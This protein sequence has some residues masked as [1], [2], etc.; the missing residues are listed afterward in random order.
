MGAP[1]SYEE[2]QLQTYGNVAPKTAQSLYGPTGAPPQSAP[3]PPP[4]E[5]VPTNFGPAPPPANPQPTPVYRE[6]APVQPAPVGPTPQEQY[7]VQQMP[8]QLDT[9]RRRD[10]SLGVINQ[11]GQP[12]TANPGGPLFNQ[13][14]FD[15]SGRGSQAYE[16]AL[17]SEA[18]R[19][20]EKPSGVESSA[21]GVKE[22]IGSIL[23]DQLDT[24]GGWLGG[25][26]DAV[27]GRVGV[28][29]G[30]ARQ[31]AQKTAV[32]PPAPNGQRGSGMP[33]LGDVAGAVARGAVEGF[34]AEPDV[35]RKPAAT[36]FGIVQGASRPQMQV[37]EVLGQRAIDRVLHGDENY[38]YD[39][40]AMTGLY[41]DFVNA[42]FSPID[43]IEWTRRPDS[44]PIIE[45][46][47]SDGYNGYTGGQAIYQFWRDQQGLGGV[48]S[49][50]AHDPTAPLEVGLALATGGGSAA[51]EFVGRRAGKEAVGMATANV[52]RNVGRTATA[53]A[54]DPFDAGPLIAKGTRAVL[55]GVA[56]TVGGTADRIY[57]NVILTERGR[58]EVQQ[59]EAEQIGQAAARGIVDRR[60]A[61][62][63]PWLFER[64]VSNN[65][66]IDPA[67]NRPLVRD[68]RTG[69]IRPVEE[70]DWARAMQIMGTIPH[71]R[72]TQRIA[73]T[74]SPL[75][76]MERDWLDL[77][78]DRAR[79]RAA[80]LG[81]PVE[82]LYPRHGPQYE[83]SVGMHAMRMQRYG[84]EVVDGL[85][86]KAKAAFDAD[87]RALNTLR[88]SGAK[89]TDP[90]LKAAQNR[91]VNAAYRAHAIE[92]ARAIAGIPDARAARHG[93]WASQF[94][95]VAKTLPK[96]GPSVQQQAMQAS[97]AASG[98]RLPWDQDL[99]LPD[100]DM[101]YL[102]Q[103]MSGSGAAYGEEITNIVADLR[104]LHDLADDAAARAATGEALSKWD[105][106]ELTALMTR[107]RHL[108]PEGFDPKNVASQQQALDAIRAW[109]EDVTAQLAG[110]EFRQRVAMDRGYLDA[111]GNATPA[112]WVG[113]PDG[114]LPAPVNWF[115]QN[116]LDRT[117]RGTGKWLLH[118][119]ARAPAFAALQ[120]TGNL[121]GK[122][123]SQSSP[124]AIVSYLNPK[125]WVRGFKQLMGDQSVL[126]NYDRY[127]QAKGLGSSERVR[128]T[129]D[130][131]RYGSVEG[132]AKGYFTAAKNA[133][134][135]FDLANAQTAFMGEVL[136][137]EK[138]LQRWLRLPAGNR[139]DGFT[140]RNVRTPIE[141]ARN[142]GI[143]ATRVPDAAI[144]R[145]L[146]AA[147]AG[148]WNGVLSAQD[149][150]NALYRAANVQQGADPLIDQWVDRVGR[151]YVNLS[152][153][154]EAQGLAEKDRVAFSWNETK[155]D[156][157]LSRMFLFHYWNSRASY[158]YTRNLLGSPAMLNA[159]VS[160]FRSLEQEAEREGYPDWLR[161]WARFMQ[162]P[163][164]IGVFT[165]PTATF[166]TMLTF[167]SEAWQGDDEFY[168]RVTPLGKA[169]EKSPAMVHPVWDNLFA[170]SGMYGADARPS[171]ILP[172]A[173]LN[174]EIYDLA[175][176][177]GVKS[178]LADTPLDARWRNIAGGENSRAIAEFVQD[179]I[180]D[181]DEPMR[182]RDPNATRDKQIYFLMLQAAMDSEGLTLDQAVERVNQEGGQ[183][184]PDSPLYQSAVNTL[185]EAPFLG[186]TFGIEPESVPGYLVGAIASRLGPYPARFDVTLQTQ[187]GN[188]IGRYL[189]MQD[190]GSTYQQI[191]DATMNEP[192]RVGGYRLQVPGTFSSIDAGGTVY[193]PDEV[194][195]MTPE[196]RYALAEQ[197]IAARFPLPEGQQED[198]SYPEDAQAAME[199]ARATSPE[200]LARQQAA[201]DY[202]APSDPEAAL[203]YEVY[204]AIG[205][206]EL[207]GTVTL[208]FGEGI[209]PE[210]YDNE[211]LQKLT[212]GEKWDI[213]EAWAQLTGA[214]PLI[215]EF[216]AQQRE[217]AATY[218]EIA[219]EMELGK[220]AGEYAGGEI[221]F[222]ED[223]MALN[224]NYAEYATTLDP[225]R[226]PPGSKDWAGKM[227]D[228]DGYLVLTG[229]RPRNTSPLAWDK[230]GAGMLPEGGTTSGLPAAN[231]EREAAFAEGSEFE[232]NVRAD[233][234]RLNAMFVAADAYDA[235]MGYAP[236][237]SRGI[238]LQQLVTGDTKT[239]R[240]DKALYDA[241][242]AQYGTEYGLIPT[243][244]SAARE[245]ALWAMRQPE[246]Q[247]DLDTFFALSTLEW[248]A[249]QRAEG[250]VV[251]DP[252]TGQ[253]TVIPP[254]EIERDPA[255]D[256]SFLSGVSLQRSADNSGAFLST[257]PIPSRP[258]QS[259][260]TPV[261]E[262]VTVGALGGTLYS[263]PD[264][265]SQPLVMLPADTP[266][267]VVA[268]A[269]RFVQ[270]RDPLGMT[271]YVAKPMLTKGANATTA[272]AAVT[273]P[274]Q[275]PVSSPTTTTIPPKVRGTPYVI[276]MTSYVSPNREPRS[277]PPE[278]IVYHYTVGDLDSFAADF[279]GQTGRQASANYVVDRD[280]TIY[281]FVDP[282]D[283]AWTH[284]DTNQ[285]RTDLPWLAEKIAQGY[286]IN[287]RAIGIEIVNA[288]NA[289]KPGSTDPADFEP[290]T[291][292]QI[293]AVQ[294]L[295]NYLVQRYGITP[296]RDRLLGHSD[297]NSVEKFDPGP[298]FPLEQIILGAGGTV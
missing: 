99:T 222:V 131:Q 29:E 111:Q 163:A 260:Y 158:L 162:T 90:A 122:I 169:R 87:L 178:G 32:P 134:G 117:A 6:P 43:F 220:M 78:M 3:P 141:T 281:Q 154:I 166:N 266:L 248:R 172:T 85:Y 57:N 229:Q 129:L 216:R 280:G 113:N 224:P 10:V 287:D 226:Y 153:K 276:D 186:T 26:R 51:A 202:W 139:L 97:G 188:R 149:V 198:F 128:S 175:N 192:I 291:P 295:T 257:D 80:G 179:R 182:A 244:E 288:G 215:E 95:K 241:L 102:R 292:E 44:T 136:V 236:G 155:A 35:L 159:Y 33:G 100:A 105:Q 123:I 98:K 120:L 218:P 54:V 203:A 77:G 259:G 137:Q 1:L 52:I 228:T 225:E 254:D 140:A 189:E 293:A 196:Q 9:F 28:S 247:R 208:D 296:S 176:L 269:G 75:E 101:D 14:R 250:Q 219:G 148:K 278:G 237:T 187:T 234:D 31:I 265:T 252:V 238:M 15:P 138:R 34:T 233:V 161:G 106:R 36:L 221:R 194:A 124:H 214:A 264:G 115:I 267:T 84:Q 103:T 94:V 108:L 157:V 150:K 67:T 152:R 245:Y 191:L 127:T 256:A 18:R 270:V 4:Q 2:W 211:R 112:G 39:D 37:T 255:G 142:M 235:E 135:T 298:L 173:A 160:L 125:E 86:E 73:G 223:L 16:Q 164:G 199:D 279:M 151:D 50:I 246:D 180:L 193:T 89:P 146:D 42:G 60:A 261:A 239:Y 92:A 177:L 7:V 104:R 213:A 46:L 21:I 40:S 61:T 183:F 20:L 81:K 274:A 184:N 65:V 243:G 116:V 284:G 11:Q 286:N 273:P 181:L 174:R 201:R 25:A 114:P 59:R 22:G 126:T 130:P 19:V 56:D 268:D 64:D 96:Y 107:Y 167:G 17:Y 49:D 168:N 207:Q 249:E 232:Q 27:T 82:M 289:A 185:V 212:E 66:R 118:N 251:T 210:V 253:V 204:R 200:M 62:P 30:A 171:Q 119:P 83:M 68:P 72:G 165:N 156:A 277:A 5:I 8:A 110:N 93:K 133:A 197:Y 294:W 88:R 71:V 74:L 13:P 242:D 271:G 263:A 63:E 170:I 190:A 240:V 272:S 282:D 76:Q 109:N 48:V 209:A 258:N 275:T 205:K 70:A 231:A 230:A 69:V 38:T 121:A 206:A 79:M 285:P 24:V 53:V 58:R 55:P 47:A 262:T 227:L 145:E 45:R 217:I 283:A 297:I 23:P 290:Y 12:L 143:S 147:M 91:V 144:Q 195:A 132:V 41:E